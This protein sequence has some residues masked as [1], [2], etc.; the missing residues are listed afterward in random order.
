MVGC[1]SYFDW[2]S[3]SWYGWGYHQWCLC[4]GEHMDIFV[5]KTP[6]QVILLTW[7]RKHA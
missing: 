2:L 7:L 3:L 1:V 5:W 4:Y 6:S